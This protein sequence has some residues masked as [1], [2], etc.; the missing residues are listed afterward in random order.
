MLRGLQVF[1]KARNIV[2]TDALGGYSL[3][4]SKATSAGP[5]ITFPFPPSRPHDG[6]LVGAGS[7]RN[8]LA[9]QT[10]RSR[11]TRQLLKTLPA[12]PNVISARESNR[13]GGR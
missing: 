1:D 13:I 9:D 11:N 7:A 5:Q 6:S 12:L 4:V 3:R 2:R 8:H 10:N